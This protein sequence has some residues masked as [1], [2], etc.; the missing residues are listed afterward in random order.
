MRRRIA[1][2]ITPFTLNSIHYQHH[3]RWRFRSAAISGS[4]TLTWFAT[5]MILARTVAAAIA[6][7]NLDAR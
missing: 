4:A 3:L 6:S 2:Q 5:A 7:S 1:D